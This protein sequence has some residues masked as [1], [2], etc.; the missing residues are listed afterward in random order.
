MMRDQTKEGLIRYMNDRVPTSDFLRAVL[1]NDLMEAIGRADDDN[2]MN[3]KS[4][5][6]FVYMDMPSNC[7]GSPA[8]V[9]AWLLGRPIGE[10]N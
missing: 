4:I 7:H 2:M 3:L 5:C 10:P 1:S 9:D 6:Q 8:K